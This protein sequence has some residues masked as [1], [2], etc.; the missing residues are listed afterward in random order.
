[1]TVYHF[2]NFTFDDVT[3]E[4]MKK[5]E[6]VRLTP[7]AAEMLALL[8]LNRD[9]PV[10]IKALACKLFPMDQ[11]N[12]DMV[13]VVCQ[14]LESAL[15][16][17]SS[18]SFF[19]KAVGENA[20]LWRYSPVVVFD[21]RELEPQASHPSLKDFPESLDQDHLPQPT[22][23]QK[24]RLRWNPALVFI[25]I[26]SLLASLFFFSPKGNDLSDGVNEVI[27]LPISNQVN[28][29][30]L[31]WVDYGLVGMV[32]GYIARNITP[33]MDAKLHLDALPTQDA[34]IETLT[35]A[36]GD[37]IVIQS[38]LSYYAN[39]YSLNLLLHRKNQP[40]LSKN[41]EAKDP[42]ECGLKLVFFLSK[43][44]KIPES[45]IY[46]DSYQKQVHSARNFGMGIL[47]AEYHNLKQAVFYLEKAALIDP[48][49]M[50]GKI[51]LATLLGKLGEGKRSAMLLN[52]VMAEAKFADRPIWVRDCL[53]A[54]AKINY[55]R[56]QW[57]EAHSFH[58]QLVEFCK[59]HNFSLG[60]DADLRLAEL[61]IQLGHITEADD[62]LLELFSKKA[63][64]TPYHQSRMWLLQG[65]LA[66][67][68]GNL[69]SSTFFYEK[70]YTALCDL[71]ADE[72]GLHCLLGLLAIYTQTGQREK[73]SDLK[74][75][76]VHASTSRRKLA[77]ELCTMGL[78]FLDMKNYNQALWCFQK[79][80]SKLGSENGGPFLFAE[81]CYGLASSY[82]YLD[83]PQEGLR[84]LEICEGW[85]RNFGASQNYSKI[86]PSDIRALS[87]IY[88]AKRS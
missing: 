86:G 34:L 47:A 20:L 24:Y 68:K 22:N 55:Q 88:E 6:H 9:C 18:A 27:F 46:K 52:R 28:D 66:K 60:P 57:T 62:L 51:H 45:T 17:E 1:M 69:N 19:I 7:Q 80:L 35:G 36:S 70:A 49:N 83:E 87:K 78:T 4:L 77:S 14:E 65:D 40:P 59:R 84:F 61:K 37:L 54:F 5:N 67:A 13:H 8:L 38:T 43:Y 56:E 25:F 44:L 3:L 15:D 79:G 73:I 30:E 16:K 33:G 10:T 75:E 42:V 2:S 64:L 58:S 81:L 48:S 63:N 23:P 29:P 21:Q 76:I 32:H 53:E 41:I 74:N 39:Q 26:L 11:A 82:A 72:E 50:P 12:F 85:F 31:S 71:G